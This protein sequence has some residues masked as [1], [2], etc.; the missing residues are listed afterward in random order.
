MALKIKAIKKEVRLNFSFG[1]GL[2]IRTPGTRKGTTVFKTAAFD[3]SAKPAK[4]RN[5]FYCEIIISILNDNV[6]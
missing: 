6:K 5:F 3:R 2:G 1:A 4:L